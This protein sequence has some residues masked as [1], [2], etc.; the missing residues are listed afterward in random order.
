MYQIIKKKKKNVKFDTP[1]QTPTSL[2]LKEFSDRENETT[3][4][5]NATSFKTLTY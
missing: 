4:L 3:Q 1:E 2:L 5:A